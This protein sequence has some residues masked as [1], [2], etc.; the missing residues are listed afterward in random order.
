MEALG[1]ASIQVRI[2]IAKNIRTGRLNSLSFG[3]IFVRDLMVG[4]KSLFKRK[5]A[6][7][8]LGVISNCSYS[9]GKNSFEALIRKMVSQ[10]PSG[11]PSLTNT[12]SNVDFPLGG[13]SKLPLPVT[14]VL[15]RFGTTTEMLPA[16]DSS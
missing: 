11:L 8:A 2:R 1:D 6:D 7:R 15:V 14:Q 16:V 9:S 12:I 10:V 4:N 3:S 13:L 5:K